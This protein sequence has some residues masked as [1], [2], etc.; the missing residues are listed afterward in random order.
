LPLIFSFTL[1]ESRLDGLAGVSGG[2]AAPNEGMLSRVGAMASAALVAAM[3]LRNFRRVSESPKIRSSLSSSG[4]DPGGV[5]DSLGIVYQSQERSGKVVKISF[6]T[7]TF[8]S[9]SVSAAILGRGGSPNRPQ[10]IGLR[11]K[12]PYAPAG[13]TRPYLLPYKMLSTPRPNAQRSTSNEEIAG[14]GIEPSC[15]A[16]LKCT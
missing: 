8:C 7:K 5:S 3:R 12:G 10:A 2:S 11:P 6:F 16:A 13:V 9:D 4:R 15:L 14:E 1:T